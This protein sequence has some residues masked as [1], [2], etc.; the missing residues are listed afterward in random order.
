MPGGWL[1]HRPAIGAG[2]DK[3]R[4]HAHPSIF[5]RQMLRL[6]L[7]R[8]SGA[9]VCR[10]PGVQPPA[11]NAEKAG[12]RHAGA[13]GPAP[14]NCDWGRDGQ[15]RRHAHSPFFIDRCAA[16]PAPSSPGQS[17]AGVR[18]CN[19]RAEA[20]FAIRSI[21]SSHREREGS[22]KS[23]SPLPGGLPPHRPA[24]GTGMDNHAGMTVHYFSSRDAPPD[25]SLMSRAI[26][27]RG[28]GV[29]PPGR[30]DLRYSFCL[31][32]ALRT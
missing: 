23:K 32:F 31:L 21:V 20:A 15:P 28:P 3:I 1:P 24:I 18:G 16:P 29:Q 8:M 10:G 27:C 17:C 14:Q 9:I 26:V 7:P 19:P 13:G 30:G 6:A 11:K 12:D 25:R 4:Q 5:H 2:M 22:G